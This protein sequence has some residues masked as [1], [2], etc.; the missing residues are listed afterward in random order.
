[1]LVVEHGWYLENCVRRLVSEPRLA[2]AIDDGSSFDLSLF[3]K[4]TIDQQGIGPAHK[5]LLKVG[6]IEG[7]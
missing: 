7:Y 1:M 6:I 4:F 2:L 3:P 5:I